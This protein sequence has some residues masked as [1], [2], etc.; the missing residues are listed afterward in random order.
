MMLEVAQ[1][2][3]FSVGASY[4]AP[5][6]LQKLI[7]ILTWADGPGFHISRLWR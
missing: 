7:H 5:S 2:L 4:F 6:A 3:L 1:S